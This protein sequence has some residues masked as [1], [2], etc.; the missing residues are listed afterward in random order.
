MRCISGAADQVGNAVR[1]DR[2]PRPAHCSGKD[3]C[4]I[5]DHSDN[6]VRLGFVTDIEHEHLDDGRERATDGEKKAGLPKVCPQCKFLKPPRTAVC[7]ACG[8]KTA[9]V[10]QG[11]EHG[12]GELEEIKRKG[13]K[14]SFDDKLNTLGQLLMIAKRR[15]RS[16]GWASHKYREIYGVWPANKQACVLTEPTPELLSWVNTKHRLRQ[17]DG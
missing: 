5:L 10:A 14:V 3:H 17:G 1:S 11:V 15:G 8:F 7:P 16:Q 12:D 2:R 4:L 13:R 6:H 9:F